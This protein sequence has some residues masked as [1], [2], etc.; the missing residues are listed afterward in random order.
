MSSCSRCFSFRILQP[1][2]GESLIVSIFPLFF[3]GKNIKAKSSH[4][5]WITQGLKRG[6]LFQG[7]GHC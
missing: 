5:G 6:E 7:S 4:Q 1:R 2:G 3:L